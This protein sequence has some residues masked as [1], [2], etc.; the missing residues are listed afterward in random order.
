M[1]VTARDDLAAAVRSLRDW[2][3]VTQYQHRVRGFNYRM[4]AIQGAVLG[5]KL[6]HLDRW[7]EARR[8]NAAHFDVA[9]RGSALR[10]PTVR[11]WAS[12][13]YHLYVVRSGARDAVRA[14]LAA[15]GIEARIHYPVPLH[16]VEAWADLGYRRGDFPEAE[17]AAD[18][19]L[20]IPVHPDLSA[21]D[22]ATV[23]AA[24]AAIGQAGSPAG[25]LAGVVS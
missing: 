25:S 19:V 14:E 23:Q 10:A 17:A 2:G 1:V 22:V 12:H 7:I 6:P 4:E 15:R 13:A 9:L 20:S 3:Q 11:D 8:R 21:A 5:V 18:E 16:L 24:L